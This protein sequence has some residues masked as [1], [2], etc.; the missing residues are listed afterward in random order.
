MGGL[1]YC[2]EPEVTEPY[3][4]RELGIFLYSAEELCYYK[5]CSAD[6]IGFHMGESVPVYRPSAEAAGAGG[7][8]AGVDVSAGG[9]VPG[10]FG[11]FAGYPL[12][13]R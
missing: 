10:A 6:S 4:V 9:Y 12:L 3:Y 13:R 2:R 7:E 8:T 1:I 11:H 5:L